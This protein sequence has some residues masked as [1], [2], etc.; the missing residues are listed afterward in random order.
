MTLI[1]II[2]PSNL[3]NYSGTT[4]HFVIVNAPVINKKIDMIL[5][6]IYNPNRHYRGGAIMFSMHTTEIAYCN[7][8]VSV[9]LFLVSVYKCQ[10]V[11]V[12]RAMLIVQYYFLPILFSMGYTNTAD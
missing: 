6:A 5:L 7:P 9:T 11:L 1:L 10:S 2:Q 12:H 8:L 3:H 4:A